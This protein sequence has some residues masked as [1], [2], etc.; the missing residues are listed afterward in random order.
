L[1]WEIHPRDEY[2]QK[3]STVRL[4][5]NLP[6][7]SAAQ[8][9]LRTGSA[10]VAQL[11]RRWLRD[12]LN[13]HQACLQQSR[14]QLDGQRAQFS[15]PSNC[16]EAKEAGGWRPFM[17]IAGPEPLVQPDQAHA[18]LPTRLLYV[19][20]KESTKSPHLVATADLDRKIEYLTLSH[21]WGKLRGARLVN[22]NIVA[23]HRKLSPESLS[24]TSRDALAITQAWEYEYLWIDSL[25]MIQDDPMDWMAESVRMGDIY[26]N[27]VCTIAALST[28]NSG[29]GCFKHRNPAPFLDCVIP[30]SRTDGLRVRR[31]WD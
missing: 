7:R 16:G 27:C 23:F 2:G 10:S 21:C 20:S 18:R 5:P 30:I 25:C 24:R 26:Q 15:I 14:D 17:P 4:F 31:C 11:V 28:S 6:E 19:P 22:E 12:C 1:S 13:N 3:R 29:E 9:S 8:R